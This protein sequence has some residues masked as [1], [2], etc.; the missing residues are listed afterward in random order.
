MMLLRCISKIRKVAFLNWGWGIPLIN[1]ANM[2]S[3]MVF[4]LGCPVFVIAKALQTSEAEV[5]K[6]LNGKEIPPGADIKL[7]ALWLDLVGVSKN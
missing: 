3:K 5:Y 7:K 4:E 1:G 6:I 2:I